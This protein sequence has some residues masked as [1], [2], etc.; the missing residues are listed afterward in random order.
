VRK[1]LPILPRIGLHVPAF[2]GTP[3]ILR[4]VIFKPS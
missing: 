3:A 4:Q 1:L 2:F